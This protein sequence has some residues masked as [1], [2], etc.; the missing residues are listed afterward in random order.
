MNA[1]ATGGDIFSTG[2]ADNL[3]AISDVRLRRTLL[4]Y[5]AILD[6]VLLGITFTRG[7]VFLHCNGRFS[8]MV[9]WPRKELVGQSTEIVH[10]SAQAFAEFSRVAS[11]ALTRGQRFDTEL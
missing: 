8:E 10:P 1:T 2:S 3:E 5:Q 7:H 11:P 4:E 9:G 6:N